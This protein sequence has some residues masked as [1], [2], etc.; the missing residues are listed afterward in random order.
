M[1]GV[2]EQAAQTQ[3]WGR[4]NGFHDGQ[5][6]LGVVPGQTGAPRADVDLDPH[7]GGRVQVGGQESRAVRGFDQQSQTDAARQVIQG[8]DLAQVDRKRD[9]DIQPAVCGKVGGHFD[10]GNRDRIHAVR[11]EP[12]A[13][14]GGLVGFK[15]RP[16]AHAG[17]LSFGGHERDVGFCAPLVQQQGGLDD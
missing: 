7:V 8:V 15:V 2:R 17:F 12:F 6:P 5:Q 3:A 4:A 14:F 11:A 1:S 16:E 9:G 10:G 13:N